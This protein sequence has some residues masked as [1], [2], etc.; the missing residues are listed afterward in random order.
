MEEKDFSHLPPV[1]PLLTSH[2]HPSQNSTMMAARSALLSKAECV[3]S[4]LN[5]EGYKAMALSVR[6]LNASSLPANQAE[7]QDDM[8][9]L[10]TPA[11][12]DEVCMVTDLC[13]RLHRCSVQASKRAM[14]LM[15]TQERAR[16]LN[17]SSLSQKEKA[18]LV[19][20]PVNSRGLFSLAVAAMQRRCEEKKK[21]GEALQLCLPR[22]MLPPPP[23]AAPW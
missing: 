3:Q 11:L 9:A 10:P 22:K 20:I 6:T 15:V 4:S 18:Q 16:W 13:L 21:E 14:A 12:W 2:L 19:D 23:P 1:E 17:L 7:Q 8:S 5:E